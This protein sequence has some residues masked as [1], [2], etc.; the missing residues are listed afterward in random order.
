MIRDYING[1]N[2]ALQGGSDVEVGIGGF[3][4]FVRVSDSTDY[5]AQVPTQVLEDGSVAT[6]HII[7]NPLTMTISGEVSDHHIR[8][9]P[10]LPITIPSDSAVGQITALLPNRTQ[11]QL[12][13]IQTIGQSVMDAV[14]RAD[15]LINIG[16]NAF[17]AFNPQVASKPLRE[18]FIDFIEAVYYGKQLI[19]IDAAYRT[20]ENMA[21]TSL[22]VSRD[23]QF[24]VIRFEI[25]VQKVESVELIYTDIQQF[26]QAPAPAA[27][28]SVADETDQGAQEKTSEAAEAEE[29]RTRSLASAI[30]GR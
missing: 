29:S 9:A 24:E 2:R 19:S 6:D 27:Q 5:T 11:A 30:L 15:R 13:K 12:N 26:Y 10:P 4:L 22:S 7:N 8:L 28:S 21:I 18:Q 1:R 25:S 17:G 14:D 23:N 20:H 16:R 3:S